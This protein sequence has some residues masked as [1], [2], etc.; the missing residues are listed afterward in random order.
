MNVAK[1][2]KKNWYIVTK[3]FE[4]KTLKK[5]P[6]LIDMET[7]ATAIIATVFESQSNWYFLR[8]W[9]FEGQENKYKQ[10]KRSKN[11]K[12][13]KSRNKRQ[14]QQQ[15]RRRT[16]TRKKNV[17]NS[18]VSARSR[19]SLPKGKNMKTEWL[20]ILHDVPRV[21]QNKPTKTTGT[22]KGSTQPK[23]QKLRLPVP[24][25]KTKLKHFTCYTKNERLSAYV[26]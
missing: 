26:K 13:K 14:E 18:T 11:N 17:S 24:A 5:W 25:I 8:L 10:N 6:T 16:R 19:L 12:N 4:N 1:F 20:Y 2:E 9:N 23:Q 7:N 3:H 22:N 15:K 21:A